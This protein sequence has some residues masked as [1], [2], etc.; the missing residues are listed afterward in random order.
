MTIAE[1]EDST[2]NVVRNTKS[3]MAVGCVDYDCDSI[4]I[5]YDK[6]AKAV[7]SVCTIGGCDKP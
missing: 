1:N 3:K 5:D 6:N 2:V 7:V 4:W